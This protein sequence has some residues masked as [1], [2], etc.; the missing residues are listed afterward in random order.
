M[1]IRLLR[2]FT[3]R[4]IFPGL[5]VWASRVRGSWIGSFED[6]LSV[7]TGDVPLYRERYRGTNRHKEPHGLYFISTINNFSL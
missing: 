3:T 4:Q 1:S 6:F 2:L 7:C 5:V